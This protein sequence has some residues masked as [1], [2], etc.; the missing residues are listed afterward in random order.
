MHH[1]ILTAARNLADATH[2]FRVFSIAGT[3]AILVPEG[4]QLKTFE[5]AR[6]YPR[7]IVQTITATDLQSWLDY[8]NRFADSYSTAFFDETGDCLTGILDYHEV[9][10]DDENLARHGSHK[11]SYDFPMTPEWAHWQANSGKPMNQTGFA[12]FIEDA[13][14]DILEPTGADMLE[15]ATTLQAKTDL[16]FASGIRL[17]NGQTQLTYQETIQGKAGV[18]GKLE[19]PQV[20]K[21]GVRLYQGTPV[22]QLEARFRYRIVNSALTLW[23]ELVRPER[24]REAVLGDV[25]D[26]VKAG[27][28]TGQ[29]L[30]AAPQPSRVGPVSD[31]VT[32]QIGLRSQP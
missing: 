9:D 13:I 25:F 22:Y 27:M 30:R 14:P 23:Y 1:D 3:A 10:H 4:Y 2:P 31:S 32:R 12:L 18:N 16:A 8:W 6:T 5:D 20:I 28:T 29:L 21:I 19:I 11:I 7:R 15:I 17:D 24:T 26:R